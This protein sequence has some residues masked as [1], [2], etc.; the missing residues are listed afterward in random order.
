MHFTYLY[1]TLLL[2][3]L[4]GI[5]HHSVI[6]VLSVN[7]DVFMPVAR[8]LVLRI[9]HIACPSLPVLLLSMDRIRNGSKTGNFSYIMT[10]D[11][12]YLQF[13]SNS[14]IIASAASLSNNLCLH[15]WHFFSLVA[16]H[17]HSECI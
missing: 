13:P 15:F 1:P 11:L 16:S 12:P 5:E 9:M 14:L 17:T 7:F 4:H 6:C 8:I 2:T 10:S 3:Y